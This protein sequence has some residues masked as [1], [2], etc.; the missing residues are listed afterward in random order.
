MSN[1]AFT[2]I[3]M[4]ACPQLPPEPQDAQQ[5]RRQGASFADILTIGA[6]P[7]LGIY[8]VELSKQFGWTISR[9][10][11]WEAADEFL[12]DTKAAVAICEE[13]LPDGSW[14]DAAGRLHSIPNAPALVVIGNNEALLDE[15][16]AFGGFDALTGP[17]RDSDVVW[18]IASAW[19]AWMKYFENGGNGDLRCSGA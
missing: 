14:R 16:L 11:G 3:S 17:L 18:S 19:Q 5:C 12:R 4:A 8:L 15:V 6:D 1:D 10:P 13:I 9:V 7:K 2:V